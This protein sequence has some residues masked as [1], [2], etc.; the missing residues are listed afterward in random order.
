MATR[1]KARTKAVS[2]RPRKKSPPK[3]KV[4]RKAAAPRRPKRTA[5]R[6]PQTLRLESFTPSLTA[7]DLTKSLIF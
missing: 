1:K 7:T 3:S 5:A 6:A 2:A 4:A